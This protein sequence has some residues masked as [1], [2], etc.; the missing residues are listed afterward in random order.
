M[1][2]SNRLFVVRKYKKDLFIQTENKKVHY[3]LGKAE[4]KTVNSVT[5]RNYEAWLQNPELENNFDKA[6][7]P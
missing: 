5:V 6:I 3:F 1:Q 2:L 7:I 4:K